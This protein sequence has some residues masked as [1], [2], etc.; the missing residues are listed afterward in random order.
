[1]APKVSDDVVCQAIFKFLTDGSFPEKEA[2]V[3]AEFP[4]TAAA[5]ELRQISKAR[6]D[7]ENEISALSRETA[8]DVDGWISQAK[9]LHED[10]ERSR[11]TAREI[12]R[13]HEKGQQLQSQATDASK[14]VKL[15]ENEIAFNEAVTRNL[16][17]IRTIDRRIGSVQMAI[18]QDDLET[19]MGLLEEIEMLMKTTGLPSTTPVLRILS[20]SVAG[21]RSTMATVLRQKW[22]SLVKVDPELR[23]ITVI[24]ST[25]DS[26]A[27]LA[28]VLN[29]L[30]KLDMLGSVI[31]S[32]Y[33]DIYS[34]I[35][36]PILSPSGSESSALSRDGD[37]IRLLPLPSAPNPTDIFDTLLSFFKYL[38]KRLPSTVTSL[39]TAKLSPPMISSLI[40]QKLVPS[41][42][43]GVDGM[44]EFQAILDH[45]N[46][47]SQ[48]LSKIGCP[49]SNDLATFTQQLPRLWINQRRVKSLDQVRVALS[50]ST[51]ETRQVERVETEQVSQKDQVFAEKAHDDWNAGWTSDNE[52]S[53]EKAIQ[54]EPAVNEEEDDFSAWDIDEPDAVEPES[55][56][57]PDDEVGDEDADAW[58][59][60]DEDEDAGPSAEPSKPDNSSG[61]VNGGTAG[62]Q[63]SP[64]RE[65]TLREFYTVTDIPDAIM[66]IIAS[67]VSDSEKFTTPEYS[68]LQIASSGPALLALPTLVIAM[69][70]AVAPMFYS[71]KFAGGEMFLYNDSVYLA[72]QLRLLTERHNLSRLKPD[73]E[74]IEKFGKIAYSREMQSQRTILSDLLDGSQGFAN[75]SAQ[76]YLGECENAVSATV[77]RVRHIHREWQSILSPSALLQSIGSLLS[78]VINKIILDIEDLSDISDAESQRLAAFCN[79]I[80]K[81]EDLFLPEPQPGQ[82]TSSGQTEVV[83]MTAM[84]V[85]NWLKFQYLMNILESSLADIKY[86]WTEGELKLEFPPEEVTDLI[87]ALFA[88]SD[89]RRR[90]IVEIRR[91]SRIS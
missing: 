30:T 54:K 48:A 69:F 27:S 38:Q 29:A 88:D 78:T 86:M 71:Q 11:S 90:A 91:T 22:N 58:G 42:P 31:D 62:G 28:L 43:T 61:H 83:P 81:L 65:V 70:K 12:V 56:D 44:G 76:P 63:D 79:Q 2:I 6:E 3:S 46:R 13:Q 9:Q 80:S 24:A 18:E 10:I 33:R 19:A 26:P 32:L 35:L 4:P 59:W 41:I 64:R 17:D 49:G 67:H 1:M 85:P 8:S 57:K 72:E 66:G 21:L 55:K 84:Y 36:N 45:V 20:E 23:Q 14:K 82:D 16:E 7:V 87:K 89:H 73:I 50:A 40:S 39:L 74:A 34:F 53:A 5:Q 15:L 52:E 77:D 51:G 68:K 37:S 60:G 75:C 47:F 25:T